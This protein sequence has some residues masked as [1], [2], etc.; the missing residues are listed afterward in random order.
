MKTVFGLLCLL[1][2]LLALG[3]CKKEEA[4]AAR[5][6][7]V[8]SVVVEPRQPTKETFAGTIEPRYSSTLAFVVPGRVLARYVDVGDLVAENERLAAIDSLPLD[9]AVATARATL[10]DANAQ[11]ANAEASER[12]LST[13]LDQRAISSAQYEMALQAKDVTE[14]AVT[15]AR[16]ALDKAADQRSHSELRAEFAGVVTAVSVEPGQTVAPG[17]PIVTIARPDVRE[18]VIDVPDDLAATLRE[19]SAFE[20][21]PQIFEG[22]R[23][24]GHVREIEPRVDALTKSRR[25]KI[26]LTEP[27]D[28][29]RLGTTITAHL[30]E[31]DR[32]ELALPRTAL[33]SEGGRTDVW[34]V[35]PATMTVSTRAVEVGRPDGKEIRIE[36]GLKSGDRVVIV[37]VHSLTPGQKVEI[38]EEGAR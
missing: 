22:R 16:A 38:A 7:P 15:Q 14:A 23:I 2:A 27:P 19:G 21:A 29:F 31:G 12:R 30:L 34:V 11:R 3:G 5:P 1:G 33:V 9:L 10:A 17:Q 6:R 36:T 37:G 13:L 32:P 18:A 35:D 8:L 28:F 24:V 25:V 4:A 20:V 26:A